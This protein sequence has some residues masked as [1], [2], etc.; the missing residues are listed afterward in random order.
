MG[1]LYT[2]YRWFYVIKMGYMFN[3]WQ[4]IGTTSTIVI[5]YSMITSSLNI[6]CH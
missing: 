2:T 1:L 4:T 3:F 6:K 5:R